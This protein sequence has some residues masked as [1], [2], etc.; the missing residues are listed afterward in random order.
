VHTEPRAHRGGKKTS[1]TCEGVFG[2][3][4]F[5]EVEAAVGAGK[6]QVASSA[7]KGEEKSVGHYCKLANKKSAHRHW[8]KEPAS[9]PAEW[10]TASR[11]GGGKRGRGNGFDSDLPEVEG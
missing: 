9:D 7:I 10:A 8:S 3:E 11:E 5:E 6:N 1:V 4:G 2:A